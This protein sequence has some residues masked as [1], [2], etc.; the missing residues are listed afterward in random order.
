MRG[1]GAVLALLLGAACRSEAPPAT[2]VHLEVAGGSVTGSYDASDRTA[3]CSRGLTGPASWGV[4]LTDWTGP[5]QGLRSLQLLI[6]SAAHP[7]QFYL[8]LVFGDLFQGTVLEIETRPASPWR[9][10]RGRVRVEPRGPG[11]TLSVAGYSQDSVAISVTIA[12]VRT[13]STRAEAP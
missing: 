1:R 11:A 3:G 4:Q 13:Q 10:G 2:S 9:K 12:C 5:K 8:G 7:D 6:P